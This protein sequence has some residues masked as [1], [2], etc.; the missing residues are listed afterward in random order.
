MPR[1]AKRK[2]A[3]VG[4]TA[5]PNRRPRRATTSYNAKA[6]KAPAESSKKMNPSGARKP[7]GRRSGPGRPSK[8]WSE[9][10]VLTSDKSP[11]ID[12][13]L[14]KLLSDPRA[15]N[16][17]EEEE[18]RE[19]LSLLPD[20]A[21]PDPHGNPEDPDSKIPPLP[22]EFL[23]YSIPWRDA[24]RQFQ[25]DLQ[26]GRYDPEWQ[27]QA[28]QAVKE[29]AEGKFDNWKE[30]QF[31][32][33]WGQKQK[34]DWGL[35]AGESSKIKLETLV[36]NQLVQVGD[37][38]K[39]TRVFGRGDDKILVEKEVMVTGFDGSCLT[40]AIPSGQNIFLRGHGSHTGEC[41]PPTV[42]ENQNEATDGSDG[43]KEAPLPSRFADTVNVKRDAS[44]R[45][46][47]N[48]NLVSTLQ[49][50]LLDMEPDSHSGNLSNGL[51][52][53][54][55]SGSPVPKLS[56][57]NTSLDE[58]ADTPVHDLKKNPLDSFLD[59]GSELSDLE[60]EFE[61]GD[62]DVSWDVY[63]FQLDS[64]AKEAKHAELETVKTSII[65]PSQGEGSMDVEMVEI[66]PKDPS[67]D[68]AD[69]NASVKV[70]PLSET[71]E[72]TTTKTDVC[73]ASTD[74][75]QEA[76]GTQMLQSPAELTLKS[77]Q[78]ESSPLVAP[79]IVFGGVRGPNS[80]HTKILKID[81][82]ITNPPNGNAWKDFRCYRNNQDMGSLWEIRQA[83][84][85][86]TRS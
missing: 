14:V 75:E 59:S 60:S 28:R 12:I 79:D 21:H 82:R 8:K 81:G 70:G 7:A 2:A 43:G 5:P 68:I 67:A 36:K 61:Y 71:P 9:P 76:N 50:F 32:Q 22:H 45:L 64:K 65:D 29:R 74:A 18:K 84:Y 24:V 73:L 42:P 46:S 41:K 33:F 48:G 3:D 23:R 58:C 11:L 57:V 44:P 47:H 27:R 37:V 66:R 26:N 30:E 16:C 85:L 17:L 55:T 34:I 62:I 38:W 25:V 53:D 49:Q 20:T 72:A 56:T 4:N 10:F 54:G 80:L 83:W 35:I 51:Q 52:T 39:F 6:P 69:P 13:D 63:R 86:R 31:E 19:I 1:G 40:F 77:A 78:P 15:W